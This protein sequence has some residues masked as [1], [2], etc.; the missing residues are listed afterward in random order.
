MSSNPSLS[1]APEWPDSDEVRNAVDAWAESTAQADAR[2][3]RVGYADSFDPAGSETESHLD[4]VLVITETDFPLAERGAEWNLAAIP[5]PTQA[6]V[7][8]PE[9]WSEII[10]GAG[11]LARKLGHETVWVYR[12]SE[13]ADD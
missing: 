13:P 6:L 12:R 3:L 7:Y 10:G 2:L 1:P 9:E 4:V 8:T 5:V 11:W